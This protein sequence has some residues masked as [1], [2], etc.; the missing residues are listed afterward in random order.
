[1]VRRVMREGT[2]KEIEWGKGLLLFYLD[3]M[4]RYRKERRVLAE[5]KKNI[6]SIN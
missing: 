1:L 5:V 3:A 2:G 4:C 6:F